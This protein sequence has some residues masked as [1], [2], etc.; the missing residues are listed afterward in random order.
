PEVIGAIRRMARP[1][2][3]LPL[4]DSPT[5]PSTSPGR[6]ANDTPSTAF[7]EPSERPRARSRNPPRSAKCTR[8]SSTSSSGPVVADPPAGRCVAGRSPVS[9][10]VGKAELLPLERRRHAG[11]DQLVRP[12]QP[13]GGLLFR[14]RL[15][16]QR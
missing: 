14:G 16:H 2:V 1:S 12:V 6:S 4:P 5:T 9:G 11:G 10:F 13:A 7:T 3:V 8:R 15:H